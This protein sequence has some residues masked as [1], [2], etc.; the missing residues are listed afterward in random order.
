MIYL[1]IYKA[2]VKSEK[3]HKKDKYEVINT[4]KKLDINCIRVQHFP[5]REHTWR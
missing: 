2:L 4:N 1:I 3:M 5:H